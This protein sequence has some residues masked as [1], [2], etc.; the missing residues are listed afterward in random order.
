MPTFIEEVFLSQSIEKSPSYV[1]EEYAQSEEKIS[2]EAKGKGG[3]QR[4]NPSAV[5]D[6]GQTDLQ[7]KITING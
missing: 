2:T 5:F 6:S 4:S 3:G 7:P 1:F